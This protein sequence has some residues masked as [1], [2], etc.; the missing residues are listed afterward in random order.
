MPLCSGK[1]YKHCCL[2]RDQASRAQAA[3]TAHE[4]LPDVVAPPGFHLGEDDLDRRSNRVVELINDGRLEEAETACQALKAQYPEVI[5]WLMRTA[6]LHEA[7]GE[8]QRAI[9]YYE[10]TLAWM[11]EHPEDFE[12]ASRDPF[13]DDIE[14]LRRSMNEPS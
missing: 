4:P 3:R 2:S 10:R 14:R 11:D 1:K 8:T 12:P 5:D 13:R 9:E 6:M 7:R